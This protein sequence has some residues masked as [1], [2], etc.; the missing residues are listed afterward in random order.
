MYLGSFTLPNNVVVSG[1]VAASAVLDI[2]VAGSEYN[3]NE[4]YINPPTNV[5]TSNDTDANQAASI[6]FLGE[7]DDAGMSVEW[8]T[9]HIVFGSS[10]LKPGTNQVMVCIRNV[11]GG[12]GSGVGN[13]D[14]ITLRGAVLHYHTTP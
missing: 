1:T 7:H 8:A 14:N 10:L 5:C 13:L 3:F 12:A 2:E 4:V 9:N 11:S 6:G